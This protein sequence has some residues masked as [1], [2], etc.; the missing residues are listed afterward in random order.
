M[1]STDRRL[2]ERALE[3]AASAIDFALGRAE[4]AELQAHLATCPACARSAVALRADAVAVRVP[5]ALLPS[6]RV[7]D[8]VYAAIAGRDARTS[9][10]VL[11]LVAA[12]ALL[13]V[14]LMG[15]AAAGA[16]LLR[17]WPTL[18]IVVQPTVPAVV[19]DAT[20]STSPAP[21][22]PP[23]LPTG[24][25]IAYAGRVG[26]RPVVHTV[27]L[28]GQLDQTLTEGGPPAWSPDGRSIVFGCRFAEAAAG[29]RIGDVCVMD[30]D[31]TNIRVVIADAL[32]PSWS[33]DGS[34]IMFS[35]SP[36][37]SGNTWL[38]D[39]DGSNASKIGDGAGSW[40]PDG[41]WILLLGASGAAPD[42]TIVRP[43]GSGAR[44]LG[45]CWNATWSPDSLRLACTWWDEVHGTLRAIDIGDGSVAT[46]LE[47]DVMVSDPAWV[48]ADQLAITMTRS[49]S[50]PS[51][52]PPANDVYLLDLGTGATRQIT[53]GLSIGG[54]IAVSPDGSWLAFTVAD[55]D[56]TD[57]YFVS[58]AGETRR[59][60]TTGSASRPRWQPQSAAPSPSTSPTASA[61]P[62]PGVTPVAAT[63][64]V[65]SGTVQL[66]PG[67][68][69]GVY[70]LVNDGAS[71]LALLDADGS[72]RPGWPIELRGWRCDNPSP[73]TSI[74]APSV[75]DD[76]SVR[77]VCYAV[78]EM[79]GNPRAFAF[80]ETGGLLAGWPVALPGAVYAQPRVI[81]D[82]LYL[83]VQQTHAQDP[84]T[85]G[86]PGTF[87]VV[88]VAAD[89]VLRTGAPYE[90]P[91]AG[92]VGS[93]RLG[94]GGTA[95]QVA[96]L[97]WTGGSAVEVT[98]FDVEGLRAGWPVRLSAC[99]S[100]V[101]V[102]PADH[103]YVTECTRNPTTTRLRVFDRDGREVA[104]GSGKLALA[105]MKAWGGAGPGLPALVVADDGTAFL[106]DD[107]EFSLDDIDGRTT[108]YRIDP[109]GS[110]AE[111]WPYRDNLLLQSWGACG[112]TVTGCANWLTL[113]AVGPGNVLYLARAAPGIDAGGSLVAIGPDG[114]VLP[115]W[116]V[117]L[118]SAR[119]EFTSVV[120]GADG[121]VY[122]LAIQ[123]EPGDRYS[124]TVLAIA[125]DSTVRSRT[126][127]V[128][129]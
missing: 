27:Q 62:A 51:A 77:I 121:T 123:P 99:T 45:D 129:P 15:V 68:D 105:A 17:A 2:H 75:A 95:Y 109:S 8:A 25:L 72:P 92:S 74:W 90:V 67:P 116:P 65:A 31:G 36:I 39:A 58:M 42:A 112:G 85:G 3:L 113:P 14:A 30:F 127:V 115:G 33:P 24:T 49:G 78:D 83:V 43:D 94:P 28:D 81:G 73:G 76:G 26:E 89:G 6:R 38:A 126:T 96:Y 23:A 1:S 18:P 124:A 47:A 88:T 71:V 13:L 60:T 106:L 41:R 104:G 5:A 29:G 40:S 103:V 82:G 59:L 37:D 4:A 34:Q 66:A 102:G 22:A 79:E 20:P 55:G 118:T 56:A 111:G 97:D 63:L 44:Q 101:A 70:V 50:S 93:P 35:R 100:G 12:A 98:A 32:S 87:R 64:P 10:R 16:F 53:S 11:V 119:A 86:Y 52:L 125:P 117:T 61:P 128:Q 84:A 54:R 21:S 46:L 120:V 122:A 91:D 107:P 48:S 80:D 7:N 69:G 114:H 108:A 19:I 9:P 110:V 57:I